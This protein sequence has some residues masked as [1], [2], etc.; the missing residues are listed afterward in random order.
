M[1]SSQKLN[2]RVTIERPTDEKDKFGHRKQAWTLVDTVWAG[3]RPMGSNERV[4]AAQM[5]SGQ[6]HVITTRWHESL[7][8]VDGA[9][10]IVCGT[11]HFNIVGLPRNIN[12]GGRWLVFDATEGGTDGH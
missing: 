10:R 9:H 2:K 3:I 4:A 7:A 11:R 12:E 6:T 1:Q 8:A 5:H